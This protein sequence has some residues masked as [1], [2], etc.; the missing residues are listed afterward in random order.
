MQSILFNYN[1][2]VV[3]IRPGLY[4]DD[5]VTASTTIPTLRIPEY[6]A[7]YGTHITMVVV[8][9]STCHAIIAYRA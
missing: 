8:G 2:T 6:T 1:D 9:V 7:H 3:A 4:V 5:L